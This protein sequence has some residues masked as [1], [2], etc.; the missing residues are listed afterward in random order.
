MSHSAR[1]RLVAL[2][3]GLLLLARPAIAHAQYFEI[4]PE[5][6]SARVGDI[7]TFHTRLH[8]GL[9]QRLTE[10]VPRPAAEL[11]E[12]MRLVS[13]D[14]MRLQKDGAYDGKMQMVFYRTGTIIVPQ[15]EVG[16]RIIGA[17]VPTRLSHESPHIEIIPLLP[18]GVQQLKDIRPLA[19]VGGRNPVPFIAAGLAVLA[20]VAWWRRPRRAAAP[21]KVEEAAAP[22]PPTPYEIALARLESLGAGEWARPDV[23]PYYH[24][25]AEVLRDYFSAIADPIDPGTTAAELSQIL[26]GFERPAA[27][28]RRAVRVFG[29]ADLVKFA[30][31]RPDRAAASAYLAEA[32]AVLANWDELSGGPVTVPAEDERALR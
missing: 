32:R 30:A 31:V 18:S 4:T 3:I 1:P 22:P 8:L 17:D 9:Q 5:R 20:L 23:V 11:P 6:D 29:D 13:A 16:L 10:P 15:F 14:T 27:V 19:P 24:A 28:T 26:A 25:V 7:I 12:G 21:V 2:G